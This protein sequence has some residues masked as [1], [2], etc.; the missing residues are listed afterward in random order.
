MLFADGILLFTTDPF[1][2]H[3]QIEN[4][5]QYSSRLGLEINV[6]RVLNMY[7]E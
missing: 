1:T 7:F 6:K 3:A 4:I 2:L 5:Y